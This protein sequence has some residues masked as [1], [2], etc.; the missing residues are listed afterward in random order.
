VIQFIKSESGRW[1]EV[2]AAEKLGIEWHKTG[3]GFTSDNP[4]EEKEAIAKARQ[5]WKLAQ[6][7]ITSGQYDLL[8][9]DEFTYPLHYDWLEPAAVI[10]WLKEHK[11]EDLHII[12]TGRSAPA[13]LI[14][15]ADLVTE[16]RAVKHPFEQGIKAQRGIEF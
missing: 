6:E 3:G 14:E 9:L 13:A 7:K 16:M 5:G 11:P 8:L 12:I 10:A 1:G 15:Y 4:E 2:K